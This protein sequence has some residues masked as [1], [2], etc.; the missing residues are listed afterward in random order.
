M[1]RNL[2]THLSPVSSGTS[3]HLTELKNI[4]AVIFDVYGTLF[5]SGSGDI[6]TAENASTPEA[7]K[8][9]LA[10]AGVTPISTRVAKRGVE[11]LHQN[12]ERDHKNAHD[13]D[14]QYPEVDIREIWRKTL[15]HLREDGMIGIDIE[16][17]SIERL[18]TAYE[19]RVN[20]VWPMPWLEITLQ[21][22]A[23]ADY[24]LGIISNAQFFTPLLFP[25]LLKNTLAE[26][27]FSRQL[28]TWSWQLREAKPSTRLFEITKIKLQE[29]D[30]KPEETLYVGNDMLNDIYPAQ[31]AGYKTALFAGDNRSLRLRE[32]DPRC[33][34]IKPDAIITDLAQISRVLSDV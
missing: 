11:L 13:K 30:I 2:S 4:K 26:L 17:I 23:H 7:L 6:G 3:P 27:G 20:P 18:A 24:A 12:V 21:N 16:N 33:K 14:I 8:K 1:I 32:D 15:N 22:L 28:L 10:E 19:C 25:A 31:K 29:K 9:S 5:I 34:N